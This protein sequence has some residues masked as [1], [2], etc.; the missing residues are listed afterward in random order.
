MPLRRIERY[1]TIVVD[2]E[3]AQ[4]ALAHAEAHVAELDGVAM[5]SCQ[6]LLLIERLLDAA[7]DVLQAVPSTS[8]NSSVFRIPQPAAN[9]IRL[10][11]RFPGSGP[12]SRPSTGRARPRQSGKSRSGPGQVRGPTGR[13]SATAPVRIGFPAA[14]NTDSWCA[15]SRCAFPSAAEGHQGKRP[16]ESRLILASQCPRFRAVTRIPR[17]HA[18]AGNDP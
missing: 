2:L 9:E 17:S 8:T 11:G 10:T 16:C 14:S 4:V 1:G 13:Q 3:G 6:N 7:Q 15:A 18:A 12:A 5:Q